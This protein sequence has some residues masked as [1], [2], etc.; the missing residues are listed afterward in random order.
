MVNF[1]IGT[2]IK[3]HVPSIDS[4]YDSVIDEISPIADSQ[5]GNFS[6]K[7]IIQNKDGKLKPGMFV[8]CSL[9]K[10]EQKTYPCVPDT[11]LIS[12]N[13]KNA[14]VFSVVNN[15]AV[16]KTVNIVSHK[17]GNIWIDSGVETGDLLINK[18]SPFLKEGQ[19]VEIKK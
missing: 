16:I 11:V 2:P 12:N 19:R 9:L 10:G 7:T 4:K 8:R 5:S 13:D 15:L 6:V 17:D 1:E 18:P 3:L 14:K